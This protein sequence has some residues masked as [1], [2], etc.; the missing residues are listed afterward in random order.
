MNEYYTYAYLREDGTPYYIGKGKGRRIFSDHMRGNRINLKPKD[1]SKIIFL[2]QNL[3]ENEA[4]KHEIYMIAVFGRID[5][6]TGIL[7][8][9]TNGGEGISG[10]THSEE[11]KKKCGKSGKENNFYG[12]RH[13]EEVKRIISQKAKQ[14]GGNHFKGLK[15]WNNGIKCIR[16]KECPGDGWVNG[17]LLTEDKRKIMRERRSLLNSNNK[18]SVGYKWWNNG[19]ECIRS[20][21][22]PG[23]E[24]TNGRIMKKESE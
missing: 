17:V 21:E 9:M 24:W 6:R 13:T 10:Y 22:C 8:N 20:K 23:I 7:H 12:K 1:K 3:T 16:S 11:R 19:I 18:F 14:R 15:F 5:L 2:K 4:I